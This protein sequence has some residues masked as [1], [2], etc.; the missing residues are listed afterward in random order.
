MTNYYFWGDTFKL[1]HFVVTYMYLYLINFTKVYKSQS[2][3]AGN[4]CLK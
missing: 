2:I 3:S 4:V 1:A